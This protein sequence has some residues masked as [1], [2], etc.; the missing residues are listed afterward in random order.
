MEIEK[1][2]ELIYWMLVVYGGFI[3]IG[4]VVALVVIMVGFKKVLNPRIRLNFKDIAEIHHLT[5]KPESDFD[6]KIKSPYK[7]PVPKDPVI[8]Y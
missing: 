7:Y 3:A 5:K 2:I 1:L 4:F 8:R 6:E